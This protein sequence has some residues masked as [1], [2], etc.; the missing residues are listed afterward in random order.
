MEQA[1]PGEALSSAELTGSRLAVRLGTPPNDGTAQL[2]SPSQRPLTEPPPMDPATPAPAPSR[3]PPPPTESR[4]AVR[5]GTPPNDGTAQSV[6]PSQQPLTE[7]PSMDRATPV[8]APSR[9]PPPPPGNIPQ[10]QESEARAVT[11]KAPKPSLNM[12]ASTPLLS[13]VVT[14]QTRI[15]SPISF[16]VK[17]TDTASG[18]TES[19]QVDIPAPKLQ[20]RTTTNV[21]PKPNAAIPPPPKPKAQA[22]PPAPVPGQRRSW[23]VWFQGYIS[24]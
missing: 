23:Q 12:K 17:G 2:V 22:T 14:L 4:L 5:L 8:L 11:H 16:H 21:V 15:T 13:A 9:A 7:P 20:G 18:G 24:K 6:S 3:T 10:T 1:H 19:C